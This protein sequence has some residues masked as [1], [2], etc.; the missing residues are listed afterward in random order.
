MSDAAGPRTPPRGSTVPPGR[1][2]RAPNLVALR[3][4]PPDPEPGPDR[5]KSVPTPPAPASPASSDAAL[6]PKAIWTQT[7]EYASQRTAD[8]AIVREL[9]FEG[10]QA[11]RLR[12]RLVDSRTPTAGF[13]QSNPER[14]EKIVQKAIGRRITVEVIAPAVPDQAPVP[15]A[16]DEA[17]VENP[18]VRK[19]VG[20]FDATIH[21]VRKLPGRSEG[22]SEPE[23]TDPKME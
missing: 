7:R 11:D 15:S 18:L 9:E 20:L 22:A 2:T 17:I 19:A 16:D 10:G 12:L 13:I 5:A 14:I 3:S 6:D 21:S 1:G 4:A 23:S 8:D